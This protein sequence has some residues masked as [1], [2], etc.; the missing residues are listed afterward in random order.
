MQRAGS[1]I[2]PIYRRGLATLAGRVQ[3]IRNPGRPGSWGASFSLRNICLR[4]RCKSMPRQGDRVAIARCEPRFSTLSSNG[5]TPQVDQMT[6]TEAFADFAQLRAAGRE[7]TAQQPIPAKFLNLNLPGGI[8]VLY[9]MPVILSSTVALLVAKNQR[10]NRL[11]RARSTERLCS[12]SLSSRYMRKSR[13]PIACPFYNGEMRVL[14]TRM[15]RLYEHGVDLVRIGACARR[16]RRWARS[17][18]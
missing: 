5:T 15:S 4:I 11:S 13:R 10:C 12:A 14:S 9:V 16:W 18:L 2:S 6:H 17:G 1:S 3:S 7:E 8:P